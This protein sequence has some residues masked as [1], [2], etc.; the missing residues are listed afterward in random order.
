[1]SRDVTGIAANEYERP[2]HGDNSRGQGA[3]RARRGRKTVG[4]FKLQAAGSDSI[5]TEPVETATSSLG[6][7]IVSLAALLAGISVFWF[8]HTQAVAIRCLVS[9]GLACL[10][11]IG[12]LKKRSLDTSGAISA[13]FVGWITCFA[14]FAMGV[15]LIAF[16]IS[17]SLLTRLRSDIKKKTDEEFKEGGQRNVVQVLANGGLPTLLAA[18]IA[19]LPFM[20]GH[21][22]MA[23]AN[24]PVLVTGC[25]SAF[26]AYY[27]CCCGDTWASELGV[28]SETPPRLITTFR[29]VPAGTNG[30]ITLLG[31]AA[32]G[33]GGLFIGACFSLASVCAPAGA[34]GG[35]G[36]WVSAVWAVPLGLAAGLVGS[37]I[38][39][40]LG[41]TVQFS[42]YDTL[43]DKMSG[44]PG[45][46]VEHVSGWSILNNH[47]VNFVSAALTSALAL[48]IGTRG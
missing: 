32:S 13:F 39:S 11:A 16:F 26:V 47:A 30:G 44:S 28:L 5:S 8:S 36:D 37:T 35:A 17:S 6:K 7:T 27:A 40:V 19:A 46:G 18:V 9:A 21:S 43:K 23:T 4:N 12:G 20:Q 42:G 34:V 1:M 33:A 38:D 45:P 14:S 3:H 41:A 15:T 31:T 10:I 29:V 2:M 48:A 22:M 24:L 25:L